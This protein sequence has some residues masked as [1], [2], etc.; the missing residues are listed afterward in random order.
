MYDPENIHKVLT[1]VF[2]AATG[3]NLNQSPIRI[4]LTA[5]GIDT[6]PWY[7]VQDRPNNAKKTGN[8]GLIDCAV[9]SACAPTYFSPWTINIAGAPT[10]LVDG[11]VGV[12]GNP[13]YQAC[14]EAFYYDDFD[15]KDTAVV[16]LGTGF[17]PR[18]QKVPEGLPGWV[19]WT[20]DALLDAP[21]EQQSEI[22]KRHFPG[23]LQRFDWQL[24][25]A[26]DM[27]DTSSIPVLVTCGQQAAASMDWT[28]ILS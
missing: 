22:V 26:I 12:A 11:G 3:W 1:S 25:Q 18:N 27:A 21:I 14:V 16:S 4:L 23:I 10:V 6:Q 24:P 19:E 8:L 17:S 9:A 7:F 5:T 13:V 28:K 15:P 2:G 20:V